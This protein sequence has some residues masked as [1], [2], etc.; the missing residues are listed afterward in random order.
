MKDYILSENNFNKTLERALYRIS[1]YN[2]GQK[3]VIK[4]ESYLRE[5]LRLDSLDIMRVIVE[6][7]AKYSIRTSDE[8]H[9]KIATVR[10]LYNLFKDT[11]NAKN[12]ADMEQKIK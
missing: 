8:R 7:E 1:A 12:H 5:D 11:L 4:P 10:D 9:E 2:I 6:L 3:L